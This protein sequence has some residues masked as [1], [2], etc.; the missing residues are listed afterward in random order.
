MFLTAKNTY[1]EMPCYEHRA[2]FLDTHNRKGILFK[3][4]HLHGLR[5]IAE[6]DSIEINSVST[7][8]NRRL[9]SVHKGIN[10]HINLL[11]RNVVNLNIYVISFRNRKVYRILFHFFIALS[12]LIIFSFIS[13][14][15][16]NPLRQ[17]FINA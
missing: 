16:F 6:I 5:K 10:K 15:F 8:Y 17:D 3:E 1:K 9:S 12:L 7:P 11:S 14:S 4:C 13:C 2:F